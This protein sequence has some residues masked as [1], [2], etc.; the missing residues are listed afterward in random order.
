MQPKRSLINEETAMRSKRSRHDSNLTWILLPI[1]A[2]CGIVVWFAYQMGVKT[3]EPSPDTLPADQPVA[4]ST[5]KAPVGG[6]VSMVEV[7]PP[8][9]A[10]PPVPQA[11]VPMEPPVPAQVEPP[12][13]L[14][15]PA[16][17]PTASKPVQ[18]NAASPNSASAEREL[19]QINNPVLRYPTDAWQERVEGV[20]RV[21]FTVNE[22]GDVQ[23]ATVEQSAGDQRLDDA[24]LDYVN[25]LKFRPAVRKGKPVPVTAS[26]VVTF[27]R[28]SE[29][30]APET[31]NP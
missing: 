14:P 17:A 23:D 26:R 25:R 7:P 18:K 4:T 21:S 22:H 30:T 27:A 10:S 29:T 1:L 2:V 19:A 31:S 8:M 24:A 15:K 6:K 20:T 13:T 12:V 16:P 5:S 11:T 9:S 3:A 28:D